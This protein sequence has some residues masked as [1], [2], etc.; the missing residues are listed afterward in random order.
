VAR[1]S[2][3][4]R[5]RP[6]AIA[7]S[8]YPGARALAIVEAERM[9]RSTAA[10]PAP[11]TRPLALIVPHAGWSF[12]GP[13]AATAYRSVHAGDYTRVVIVGP[14]HSGDFFGFSV[15]NWDAFATP[16]GEV[17][18]CS[19]A[20]TLRD[21]KL[22]TDVPG[23][24]REEH[25][26]EIQLPWLQDRLGAFCLIP[27][28]AG[29]TTP[30]MERALARKLAPFNDGRTLFVFSSDFVH[31]GE[32]FGY[33]PYGRSARNAR[34]KIFGLEIRA[35]RLIEAKDAPGFR[36]YLE[37]T[38]ATICGRRGLS[39]LLELLPLLGRDLRPTL[40]AHYASVDLPDA[41]SED[42]VGY[43]SL[44]FAPAADEQ[45][46]AARAL[47]APSRPRVCR[48][49]SPALKAQDGQR[50]VRI[51]RAA[52][53]TELLGTDDLVR[54]LG[55]LPARSELD[56]VQAV[57]VTLEEDG[58]LRG[59][60]GQVRPQY[61]LVEAVVHSV[62]D[63]ALNDTRFDPVTRDEIDRLSFEVTALEPLHPVPSWRRIELGRHGI[64]LA[65]RGRQA[66]FL[67]QVPGEQGWDLEQTLGALARK[68]GLGED[69][70]RDPD[71]RFYVFAGQVFKQQPARAGAGAQGQSHGS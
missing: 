41:P 27:I 22:V 3:T 25:S 8:W 57:F 60:V 64:L 54:E 66:L 44:A 6:S 13:A 20:D 1:P 21:G 39:V 31:Y 56:R 38:G 61:P 17:P 49:D 10:A 12:S 51:A 36:D 67:P 45:S 32:R 23:V 11:A 69:A 2:T 47:G 70:W 58:R 29:R 9:M 16:L 48:V 18:L 7:G 55:T 63:A 53:R 35:I 30:S 37:A 34:D 19:E 40:L 50:L 24:D 28:L 42:S 14:S 65:A 46:L 15:N 4:D 26:I 52:L 5:V 62:L 59:C 43:V 71:A 33:A 68:A